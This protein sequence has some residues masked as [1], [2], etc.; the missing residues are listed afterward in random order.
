MSAR[1]DWAR[2]EPSAIP[3]KSDLGEIDSWL[4]TLGFETGSSL[5][6]LDLGCGVGAVSRRLQ[7]R[8]FSVVGVDINAR[9]IEEARR[10]SEGATFTVRDVSSPRGLEIEGAPFDLVVSQLVLSIV[11][12]PADRRALLGN[13]YRALRPGGRFFLSASAVS[14][15]INPAYALLYERDFPSTGEIHTYFSRDALGNVLYR[16]HHFTEDE[17]RRLLEH[18][19]FVDIVIRRKR[20]SSSRRPDEAAFFFYVFSRK[21]FVER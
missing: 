8:G 9:A 11:G 12:E 15:G 3:T 19:G 10:T 5:R 2:F 4:E 20:E 18:E 7:K 6:L 21:P 14:D 1:E 17:L 16:T 13:A